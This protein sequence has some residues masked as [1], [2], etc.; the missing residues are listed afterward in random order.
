MLPDI[1]AS[2]LCVVGELDCETPVS[3][4]FALADLIPHSRLAVIQEAGHLLNVEAADDV[5]DLLIEQ[6]RRR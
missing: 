3:Y 1:T 4:A 5:N 6:L 2:T